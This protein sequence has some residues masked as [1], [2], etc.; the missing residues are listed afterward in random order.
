MNRSSFTRLL[1]AGALALA[2][3][4][5]LPAHAGPFGALF[6]FGDSL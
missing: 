2:T 1:S 3:L 4:V 5:S 6:V